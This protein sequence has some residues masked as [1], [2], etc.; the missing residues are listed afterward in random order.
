VCCLQS[1]LARPIVAQP[2]CCSVVAAASPE[3]RTACGMLRGIRPC[4]RCYGADPCGC[5]G[6]NP[7]ARKGRR[8]GIRHVGSCLARAMG[9]PGS[10][11]RGRSSSW[12]HGLRAARHWG[13]SAWLRN[14][15][16]LPPQPT[17]RVCGEVARVYIF[18]LAFNLR[19]D[20]HLCC[21]DAA[22]AAQRLCSCTR[23]SCAL[24]RDITLLW[25]WH[26]RDSVNSMISPISRIVRPS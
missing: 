5:V 26:T 12:M 20:E 19:G 21:G 4:K 15:L 8:R 18:A 9:K 3:R 17:S 22:L 7:W 2:T 23:S 25:I 14:R 6:E 16:L 10:V 1:P 11:G 24:R 13:C